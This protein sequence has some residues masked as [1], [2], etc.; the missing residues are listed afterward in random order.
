[1]VT[2]PTCAKRSMVGERVGRISKL[3][4]AEVIVTSLIHPRSSFSSLSTVG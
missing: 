3:A 1:V 4:D 2:P